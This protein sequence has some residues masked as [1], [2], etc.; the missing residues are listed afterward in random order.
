MKN[1]ENGLSALKCG[2]FLIFLSPE[3][4]G[5]EIKR[6]GYQDYLLA[7]GGR[8]LPTALPNFAVQPGHPPISRRQTPL[9]H[10]NSNFGV[11]K[12]T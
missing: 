10:A 2:C 3:P 11:T 9:P 4:R 1:E 6:L 8:L 7:N 12:V 5:R